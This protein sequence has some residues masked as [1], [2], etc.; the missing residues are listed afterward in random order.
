MARDELYYVADN[1]TASCVDAATGAAHW[2]KRLGGEYSASPVYAAGRIYFLSEAGVVSVIKAGTEYELLA[3]NDME[4]RT[5][6]RQ[7]SL[8]GRSICAR[9]RT[10]NR[11]RMSQVSVRH[12]AGLA[13]SV[14]VADTQADVGG[15][16]QSG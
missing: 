3:T 6:R 12:A 11:G 8:M 1:G 2:S 9:S 4:E 15:G 7:L 14:L 13:K 16:Q 5:W 10:C